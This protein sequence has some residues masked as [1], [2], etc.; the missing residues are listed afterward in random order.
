M[1][2]SATITS[3]AVTTFLANTTILVSEVNGNFDTFRGHI[4]PVDPATSA[5]SDNTYNIG[6]SEYG[7]KRL[8]RG[9]QSGVTAFSGGGQGSAVTLTSDMCFV[10]TSAAHGDS[11]L[12]PTATGREM[13][14]IYNQAASNYVD[15]FPAT[16]NTVQGFGTNTAYPLAA[17]SSCILASDTAGS[18]TAVKDTSVYGRYI[19]SGALSMTTTESDITALTNTAD[20]HGMRSGGNITIPITGDYKVCAQLLTA[21]FSTEQAIDLRMRVGGTA[22]L[23]NRTRRGAIVSADILSTSFS[24]VLTL[25]KGDVVV[26]QQRASVNTIALNT[27]TDVTFFSIKRISD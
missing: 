4:L 19:I 6:S 27:A 13:I 25:N 22:T 8:F 12:L 2:S 23:F 10:A 5:A 3:S 7:W 11:V 20:T 24:D 1:P 17:G 26:F 16:S 15:I 14:T 9:V 21:S 18:W